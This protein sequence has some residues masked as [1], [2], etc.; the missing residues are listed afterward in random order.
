MKYGLLKYSRSR[1]LGDRIQSLAAKQYLPQVDY[2]L[3]RDFLTDLTFQEEIKVI[4]NGWFMAEPQNWP[5]PDFI[6]PLF[7]SF[8][9]TQDYQ[10]NEKL[11][12]PESI[13]YFKKH[14]PIGCRDFYT[15]DLLQKQGVDAYY[16][17]CLTMTIP[18]Q[19][20]HLPKTDEIIFMDVLYKTRKNSRDISGKFKKRWLIKKIFPENLLGKAI[21]LNQDTDKKSNEE[22]RFL[23]AEKLLERYARAK[24]VVTSR[25]HCA[26]PCLAL[27]TPVI[28]INGDLEQLTDTTR[29]HGVLE[30]LNVYS[31]DALQKNYPGALAG[32]FDK[33]SYSNPL[34]IAWE[35]PPAN[36]QKHLEVVEKLKKRCRE[37]INSN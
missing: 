32:F 1:N 33:D 8:H 34:G 23:Q 35:N 15:R 9:I 22:E 37:F 12:N 29:F 6:K 4:M 30:Y 24:L 17:A 36:P 13:A 16:S 2:Y 18:N 7:V 26:L 11:M 14:Q 31:T 27:G 20:M 28:F 5:P 3:D 19:Y 10:A 25:I 21:I